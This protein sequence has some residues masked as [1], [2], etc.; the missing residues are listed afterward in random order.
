MNFRPGADTYAFLVRPEHMQR[1]SLA[2]QVTRLLRDAIVDLQLKPGTMLDKTVISQRLGVSRSPISDA[3]A[4]LQGEGLVE[5]LPQRGSIVSLLSVAAVEDY[6]FVRKA[7]EG[8]TVKRLCRTAPES[9]VP[10]LE[11]N[12]AEQRSA[13]ARDDRRRFHRLDLEFH[14]LLLDA[15]DYPRMKALVDVA[16]NNLD[17][18][19][20]LTN[21]N[22]RINAGLAQHVQLVAAI[23]AGDSATAVQCMET[24]LEDI[25]V[26]VH[27]L[28]TEH[29]E[30]FADAPTVPENEATAV[31]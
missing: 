26:E 3:I 30:L 24:H 16:R 11:K 12:L 2:S 31:R 14:E 4:Q 23:K 20:Q 27:A 9:L 7:L 21:S 25:V 18:V 22:R 29:P 5:V 10:R 1:G 19:R 15:V 13:V 17:R 6:I 8:A 28:A